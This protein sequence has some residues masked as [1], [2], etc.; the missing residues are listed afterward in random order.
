MKTKA[1]G[2]FF[3]LFAIAAVY[4]FINPAAFADHAEV[5][6]ATCRRF[7]FQYRMWTQQKD[8]ILPRTATVDVG[9]KV[10]FSNPE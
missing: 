6:I 5:T 3:V 4:G 7:W 8:V 2:S 9:G 1:I 10:I